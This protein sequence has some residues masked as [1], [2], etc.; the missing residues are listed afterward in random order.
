MRS[1]ERTT[2]T[3]LLLIG[4][5]CAVGNL[6]YAAARSTIP[7]SVKGE[8]IGKRVGVEK[9]PGVDDVYLVTLDRGEPLRVD[10]Q[11]FDQLSVGDGVYKVAWK[12][13]MAIDDRILPLQLSRDFY[14]LLWCMLSAVVIMLSMVYFR[15]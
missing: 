10:K 15:S 5:A 1:L 12:T 6:W 7:L 2:V 9:H 11:I 8:V 13:E 4:L 3:S 14:G